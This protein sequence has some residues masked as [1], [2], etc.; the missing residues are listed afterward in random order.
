[1]IAV[2]T[3]FCDD[4]V[5]SWLQVQVTVLGE[6]FDGEDLASISLH[7]EHGAGFDGFAVHGHCASAA[8]RSFTADVRPGEPGYL[9]QIMNEKQTRFYFMGIG[10]PINFKGDLS[11]HCESRRSIEV[12]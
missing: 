2:V 5:M 12:A 9:A 11:F 1:M 3:P 10:F 4:G 6:S 7:R 8:D